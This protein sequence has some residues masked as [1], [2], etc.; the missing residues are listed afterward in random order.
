MKRME[1]VQARKL[2][3]SNTFKYQ[4]KPKDGAGLYRDENGNDWFEEE[5]LVL[6]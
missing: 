1:V 5:D 2:F 6:A 4:V 3:G